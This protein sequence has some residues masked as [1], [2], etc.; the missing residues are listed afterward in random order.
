MAAAG[1]AIGVGSLWLF[2]YIVG[3]SGGGAFVLLYLLFT[4]LIGLP[5]F[6]SELIIGRKTQT[7]ALDAYVQLGSQ[8]W[9]FIGWLNVLSCLIILSFYSVV[10]GWGVSYTLMSLTQF[11]AGRTPEEISGVFD[12]LYASADINLLWLFVFLL[13]NVGIVY[14]GVRKGIERWS[15]ILMPMLLV[16]LVGLLAYSWTLKGLPQALRFVLYP[17]FAAITPGVILK[18]LGLA[19][20]TL[21][22]A[23]GIILT[24]GS[25]MKRDEDLPKTASLVAV[26]TVSVSMLSA[27]MIFPIVFTFG[28][29]PAS[30]PGLV[31]RTLPVMFAQ[32]PGTL[33]LSTVFFLLFVFTG[34]TSSISLMEMLTAN[35]MDHFKLSRKKAVLAVAAAAF[36]LGIPSALAG[37]NTLFS[38]WKTVYGMDFFDTMAFITSDWF[39]PIAGLLT[40]LFVG[41]SLSKKMVLEEFQLGTHWKFLHKPWYFMVRYVVPVIVILI[42]LQEAGVLNI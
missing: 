37:S 42:I 38:S 11:T 28:Y 3:S 39:M 7:C 31:F 4:F 12:T 14:A 26:M 40:I 9:R 13:I 16:F 34:L 1:S 41:W 19:F 35:M 36:V 29:E 6:I 24:Y 20:F 10:A 15:K 27:L 18:A 32:L 5:V 8:K 22:V 21:S 17:D 30:G 25:Y 33:V 23:L 2:P